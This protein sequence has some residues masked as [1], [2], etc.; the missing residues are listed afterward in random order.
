[1]SLLL[2]LNRFH[3]VLLLFH[4][5]LS[6]SQY[7]LWE[8]PEIKVCAESLNFITVLKKNVIKKGESGV[9]KFDKISSRSEATKRKDYY[10]VRYK[11]LFGN[12]FCSLM[13]VKLKKAK[14]QK[15]KKENSMS[16]NK[17]IKYLYCYS[18][19][20]RF[21]SSNDGLWCHISSAF[22]KLIYW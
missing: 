13:L 20:P 17:I 11:E 3:T 15:K 4:C 7:R 1:M 12:C 21:G 14:L 16:C 6:T 19:S 8:I 9:R 22:F 5:W 2:T 18:Y 10:K